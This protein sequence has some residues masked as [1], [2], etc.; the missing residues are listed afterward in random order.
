[1]HNHYTLDPVGW[2]QTIIIKFNLLFQ[3]NCLSKNEW[4]TGISKVLKEE[5]DD[6]VDFVNRLKSDSINRYYFQASTYLITKTY[7]NRC[8]NNSPREKLPSGLEFG[9][10]LG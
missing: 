1:M 10:G 8:L 2:I 4:V 7:M 3:E 9:F 5:C 6:I